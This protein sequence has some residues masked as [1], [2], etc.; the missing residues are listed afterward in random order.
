[1]KALKHVLISMILISLVIVFFGCGVSE[2]EY[3][4]VIG[5]LNETKDE[6]SNANDKIAQL[7]D[8]IK[9]AQAKI[10]IEEPLKMETVTEVASGVQEKLAAAQQE[11]ADLRAKVESLT[12][13]NGALK[14]M[15]DSLKAQLKELQGHSGNIGFDLLK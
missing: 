13:E 11:A 15:L 14:D 4:K 2:D 1:M 8:S 6:L 5:E 3:Q 10:G 12:D 7:E 9:A